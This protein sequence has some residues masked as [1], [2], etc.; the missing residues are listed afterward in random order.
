MFRSHEGRSNQRIR[1]A[2]SV[3]KLDILVDKNNCAYVQNAVSP[4][5]CNGKSSV[6]GKGGFG[7]DP[8]SNRTKDLMIVMP[9]TPW[10]L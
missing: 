5:L 10:R 8:W 4:L 7:V 6:T 1:Y 3:H 9:F 2:V